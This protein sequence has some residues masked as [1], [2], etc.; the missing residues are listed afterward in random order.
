[1]NKSKI[2][3]IF[4]TLPVRHLRQVMDLLDD[5]R[6]TV[7]RVS[8]VVKRFPDVIVSIG[9]LVVIAP[10]MLLIQFKP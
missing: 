8:G 7:L 3:V 6:D 5:R 9:V 4:I 10:I 2:E 1:M